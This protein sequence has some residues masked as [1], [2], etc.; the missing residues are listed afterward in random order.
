MSKLEY[1]PFEDQPENVKEKVNSYWTKR[2]D[3]FYTQRIHEIQ[4]AKAKLWLEEICQFLPKKKCKIL[5]IGCGA[6]FFEVLLGQLGHEV[7][8]IDLTEDMVKQAKHMLDVFSLDPECVSVK[9]MDGEHLEFPEESFDMILTRNVTWT[10][11]HPKEAYAEWF[12]VL[13]PGGVL[14]NFDA[15]YAKGEHKLK[16]S[17]NLAHKNIGDDL[18][19]ECH[20]IYHMLTVSALE[21][22]LWDQKVLD[23]IG[24]THVSVDFTFGQRVY[25]ERDEFYIPEEMFLIFGEKPQD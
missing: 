9:Q 24:Y 25:K 18:K 2:A 22:P 20:R 21:R 3:S 13:K 8:G 7:I 19:E 11:P 1:I 17:E 16:S 12:R 4:S 10:L 23:E 6:G 14:L 5:D 15:E